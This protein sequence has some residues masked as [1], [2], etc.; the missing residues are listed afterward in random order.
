[1]LVVKLIKEFGDFATADQH[2]M[3][4]KLNRRANPFIWVEADRKFVSESVGSLS[5]RAANEVK[6]PGRAYCAT[7]FGRLTMTKY[8]SPASGTHHKKA[9]HT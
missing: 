1:V 6:R 5:P 3:V 7:I 2:Q 8:T 9:A 4:V